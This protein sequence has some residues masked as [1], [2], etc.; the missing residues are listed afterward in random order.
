[1]RGWASWL[2][3][4]FA[5]CACAV[6]ALWAA[7][8]GETASSAPQPAA[9]GAAGA[10]LATPPTPPVEPPPGVPPPP[11]AER[12][13]LRGEVMFTRQEPAV[14][15]AVI[16]VKEGDSSRLAVGTTDNHGYFRFESIP[17]GTYTVGVVK[18]GASVVL[19]T[20]IEV[21]PPVRSI[22][23]IVL[24]KKTGRWTAPVIDLGKFEQWQAD[25][26]AARAAAAAPPGPT[27]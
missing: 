13:R 23:D 22:V 12:G 7:G 15:A 1:M 20:G 4:L 6:G 14:G 21:K 2:P 8:A 27:G 17:A 26:A 5:G 16:L 25:Q 19:K 10:S 11:S 3:V 24:K 9:A 18:E